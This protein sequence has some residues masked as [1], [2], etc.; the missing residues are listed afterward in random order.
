[1]RIKTVVKY[2][3]E[4]GANTFAQETVNLKDEGISDDDLDKGVVLLNAD[5]KINYLGDAAAANTQLL[6][7]GQ[8]TKDSQTV[9]INPNNSDLLYTKWLEGAAGAAVGCINFS[10]AHRW[11]NNGSPPIDRREPIS[12]NSPYVYCSMKSTGL[13]AANNGWFVLTFGIRE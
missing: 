9:L 11:P 7:R 6:S 4:G 13:A 8:V 10:T 3:V 5:I 12:R 2:V 1:M